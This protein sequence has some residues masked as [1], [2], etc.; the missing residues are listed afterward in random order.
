MNFDDIVSGVR[1]IAQPVGP[2]D[3]EAR[4]ERERVY[5]PTSDNNWNYAKE[6]WMQPDNFAFLKLQKDYANILGTV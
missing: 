5:G 3:A 6:H 2:T 4:K 1:N